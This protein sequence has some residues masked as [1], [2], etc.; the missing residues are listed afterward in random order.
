MVPKEL[1]D[2]GL[3]NEP[4]ITKVSFQY[5]LKGEVEVKIAK[6]GMFSNAYISFSG[7]EM[8]DLVIPTAQRVHI[9]PSD[10][11]RGFYIQRCDQTKGDI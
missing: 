1:S 7:E 2:T 3:A 9:F 6:A 5:E 11:G 4:T 10:Y 8:S